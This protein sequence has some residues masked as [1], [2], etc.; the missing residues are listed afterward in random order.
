MKCASCRR[1][2][3]CHPWKIGCIFL[4]IYLIFL[5]STFW[6][7]RRQMWGAWQRENTALVEARLAAWDV[8]HP[9]LPPPKPERRKW[10]TPRYGR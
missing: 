4:A 10:V 6:T 3:S 9:P 7:E 5:T 8:A 1:C 2:A